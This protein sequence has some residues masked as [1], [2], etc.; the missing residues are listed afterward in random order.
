MNN[1]VGKTTLRVVV[2][3]I[4]AFAVGAVSI[5][6]ARSE[7]PWILYLWALG[8]F[9]IGALFGFLFSVPRV[10]SEVNV[11]TTTPV[12]STRFRRLLATNTNLEQIS[13]WITK[14]I[15]GV[16]LVELKE[17]PAGVFQF[18]TFIASTSEA[19]PHPAITS[20]AAAIIVYFPVAGFLGA[21]LITRIYVSPALQKI[22]SEDLFSERDRAALDDTPPEPKRAKPRQDGGQALSRAA[23]VAAN[24]VTDVDLS[25]LSNADDIAAWAKGKS[26]L[27]DTGEAIAGYKKLAKMRPDDPKVHLDYGQALETLNKNPGSPDAVAEYRRAYKLLGPKT[28]ADVVARTY[29]SLIYAGLYSRPDGFRDSI[30]YGEEYV[31]TPLGERK[32]D[33]WFNLAAAY[34]QLYKRLVDSGAQEEEKARVRAKALDAV[35]KTIDLD[36]DARYDFKALLLKDYPDKKPDE[37]DLE[38]FEGDQ[39]FRSALGVDETTAK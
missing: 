5:A 22:E 11:G 30:R 19:S 16:G 37:N 10:I 35:R 23:R 3:V 8:C 4:I 28:D 27:G 12:S 1:W 6:N 36:P 39:E 18:A 21:F 13:D 24:T 32:G 2:V 14:I 25:A 15:V 7:D 38:S 26:V 17:I 34:G 33:S 31:N 9:A 29:D 20:L